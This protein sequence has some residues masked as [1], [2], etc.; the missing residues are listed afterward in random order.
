MKCAFR[1]AVALA[2][3]VGFHGYVYAASITWTPGTTI[4]GDSDVLT[5]G[6][7]D[8]AYNFGGP[9]VSSAT[10]NGVTFAPFSVSDQV[11]A[12]SVTVGGTTTTELNPGYGVLFGHDTAAGS[13]AF[14]FNNLSSDYQ[15]LLRSIVYHGGGDMLLTVNGLTVGNTYAFQLFANDSRFPEAGRNETV[16]DGQGHTTTLFYNGGTEGSLGQYTVGTFTADATSQTIELDSN[17]GVFD[18]KTA[19]LNAMQLRV[20]AV[21]PPVNVVPIP[22]A[23]AGG[24]A[25][26]GLLGAGRQVRRRCDRA[27]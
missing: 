15:S 25:L 3:F 18:F 21:A 7:L 14:P 19:Q 1:A 22:A 13:G 5:V 2:A 9:N 17:P 26:L 4:A 27:A 16:S 10:V 8:R 24:A 12:P 11:G 6:T 20:T 23:L